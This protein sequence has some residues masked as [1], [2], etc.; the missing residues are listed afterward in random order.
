M[1]SA[2]LALIFS[3]KREP[4]KE[5]EEGAHSEDGVRKWWSQVG[6]ELAQNQP[7]WHLIA[8]GPKLDSAIGDEIS[9]VFNMKR[10]GL[11]PWP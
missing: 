2:A 8:Q 5:K 11:W 6:P 4:K 7:D 9:R 10:R 3:K 1:A